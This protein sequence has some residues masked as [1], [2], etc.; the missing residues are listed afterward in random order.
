MPKMHTTKCGPLM[1]TITLRKP[2]QE[3]VL[4]TKA[5]SNENLPILKKILSVTLMVY[6]LLA[7]LW[8]EAQSHL[9]WPRPVKTPSQNGSLEKGGLQRS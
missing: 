1:L 2:I 5:L 9:Q 8:S 6:Q 4:S 7:W 3:L